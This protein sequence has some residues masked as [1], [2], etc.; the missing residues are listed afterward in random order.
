M[1]QFDVF[2]ALQ[3]Q[4]L[5]LV[6]IQRDHAAGMFNLLTDARVTEYYVVIPFKEEQDLLPVIERFKA[7]YSQQQ[8][9][10]WAITLRDTGVFIG[11]IGF[12]HFSTGH[13]AGVIYALSPE[14][15]GQ[16]YISE[17][18]SAVMKFGF[19]ELGINRIEAEVMPGNA[20]SEKVLAKN[21]FCCEGLLRQWLYWNGR[22]YDVNM[23]SVLASERR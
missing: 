3:T 16:G 5:S 11:T 4:R 19:E 17:A 9:L 18:L 21:G 15:W 8:G 13:R 14:Y 23:Y 1:H 7:Q 6:E 10:R 22:H 12:H 20:A 2:P